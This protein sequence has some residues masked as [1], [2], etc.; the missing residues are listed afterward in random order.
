MADTERKTSGT[1][2]TKTIY[3]GKGIN[4]LNEYRSYTY[5]FTLSALRKEDVKKPKNYRN[6]NLDFVVLKS[7]G[8]GYTGLSNKVSPVERPV[9]KPAENSEGK[10]TKKEKSTTTKSDKR[11]ETYQDYSGSSLVQGFNANSPGRFDMFID[12]VEIE[13]T[14]GFS[15]M[16]GVSQ[17]TAISFEVFEP[18]SINGFIESMHVAAIAA[19]YPSYSGTPFLLKMEFKGYPDSEMFTVPTEVP[20]STRYFIMILSGIDVTVDERGTKYKVSAIPYEQAGFGNPSQLKKPLNMAGSDV[21]TI[22]ENLMTGVNKQIVEAD[23]AAKKKTPA[24]NEHDEYK[25][26][27]PKWVE[28]IGWDDSTMNDIGKAVV[29]EILKD[30]NLY[31]FPDPGTTTKPTTQ[32]T[33]GQTNPSA[34]QNQKRPEYFKLEPGAPSVQFAEGKNIHECVSAIIRDSKYVRNIVEKLSSPEWQTVVDKDGMVDYFLIRME[35][36]NKEIID[37]DAQRPYQ[38]FTYVVTQHKIMYTR[39]PN[40]GSEQLDMTKIAPLS[41]REYNYIYTGKNVDV[42]NFKLNFNTLFFEAIPAALGNSSSPPSRDA[43][44]KGNRVDPKSNPTDNKRAE[45]AGLPATPRKVDASLTGVGGGD[46]GGQRQDDAYYALA[47]GMH[48]AIVNSKGA[49]LTGELEI[50]GDPYYLVTGGIGNYN[51]K[52]KNGSNNRETDDGEAC[53]NYGEV[54]VT[55]NFRNPIDV[56]PLEKGGRLFFDPELLP[57]SGIYRVN[58]VKSIFRDGLFKQSLEIMRSPG[59]PPA[60][61]NPTKGGINKPTIPNRRIETEP[62][63]ADTVSQD[64]TP[65]AREVI[66]TDGSS[67]GGRPSDLNLLLQLQRGLPSPGLP[68]ELSN[69]TAAAQPAGTISPLNQVSGATPN[70]AGNTR[71]ATQIFGGVVPGGVNQSALGIPLPARAV[72]GL[73]NRVLSPAGLVTEVGRTVANSLGL[74]GVAAQLAHDI[75]GIATTKINRTGVL[76]SGIGVGVTVPYTPTTSNPKTSYDYINQ[77]TTAPITANSNVGLDTATLAAVANLGKGGSSNL[78]N[79]VGAKTNAM[80]NG[81]K[82]D[83][84][85]IASQFGINQSQLTGLS[86]DVQ[87]KVLGQLGAVAQAVPADTDINQAASQGINLRSLTLQ[88]ISNLPPTQPYATA[89][90]PAV[91]SAFVNNIAER[92]GPNAI[93]RAY[94]VNNVNEISQNQLPS[95][96]LNSA[97][98]S[99]PPGIKNP[100]TAL[101]PNIVDVASNAAKYLVGNSQLSGLTGLLGTKEGQLLQL[102]GRYPGSPVNIVGDLGS[103][104]ISKFGSKSAGQSPL[105]KIM[106]R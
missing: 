99:T 93:A 79:N 82:A 9:E 101:P 103:S 61:E 47:K 6:S 11:E 19:G 24:A 88:G 40:Y 55:I 80:L 45:R 16:G 96:D 2:D 18:Y 69:F 15:E 56:D 46:N 48:Q 35:V 58:K 23:N 54:L 38:I 1:N 102:A 81:T 71:I 30:N 12:N 95:S 10:A 49:M 29:S 73:Q 85:A 89:P 21:K 27:F 64:A 34:D 51:P 91:D 70:L 8:K 77:Q 76:G 37:N 44:A 25:V 68:G 17:P 97:I 57:F 98:S 3:Q 86:P 63:R 78:V 42:I 74:T 5:N 92:G 59:Q 104:A 4:V 52:P 65:I 7:G 20:R 28:G 67:S 39:I 100:L 13:T 31:K 60:Q 72:P 62:D 66:D 26:R 106:I 90:A 41:L 14:M 36:E 83:P 33:R 43:A 50:Q 53:F 75:V 22:L 105:D 94:G 87:S 84:T 32:Q